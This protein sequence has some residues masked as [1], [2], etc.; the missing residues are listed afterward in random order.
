[1]A[2]QHFSIQYACV[3]VISNSCS[4]ISL[5]S[6]LIHCYVYMFFLFSSW[7][8]VAMAQNRL[9]S[10][11]MYTDTHTHT[12]E[13]FMAFFRSFWLLILVRHRCGVFLWL[14]F[15]DSMTY[16]LFLVVSMIF[17]LIDYCV[18]IYFGV[19]TMGTFEFFSL[20]KVDPRW[21]WHHICTWIHLLWHELKSKC[22]RFCW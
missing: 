5:W 2:I 14:S 21:R 8:E 6:S 20:T 13:V 15:Y 1:M 16:L 10:F 19:V 11:Y 3:D 18:Y 4:M 12:Y 17:L 22:E 7:C 9:W